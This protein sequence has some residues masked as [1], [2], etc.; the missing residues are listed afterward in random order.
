MGSVSDF[1]GEGTCQ[2]KFCQKWIDPTSEASKSCPGTTDLDGISNYLECNGHGYCNSE[3]NCHCD[4]G[5]APPYCLHRGEGGS[6]DSA[7]TCP[8]NFMTIIILLILLFGV[9]PIVLVLLIYWYLKRYNYEVSWRGFLDL[10]GIVDDR[11]P[12]V[13][14][15]SQQNN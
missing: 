4:C 8:D 15:Q 1:N 3:G 5:F 6:V 10:M 9:L 14:K 11:K 2:N 12:T 13:K 7:T